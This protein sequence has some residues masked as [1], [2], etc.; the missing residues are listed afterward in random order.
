MCAGHRALLPLAAFPFPVH[1]KVKAIF[2]EFRQS[3]SCDLQAFPLIGAK[4]ISR[5]AHQSL[6]DE[7]A[8]ELRFDSFQLRGVME[9][10]RL[11]HEKESTVNANEKMPLLSI[12]SR[13]LCS[14]ANYYLG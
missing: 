1:L 2:Q 4:R 10:Q 13:L 5:S 6:R 11:S 3:P 7:I 8:R 12:N 9:T 14:P